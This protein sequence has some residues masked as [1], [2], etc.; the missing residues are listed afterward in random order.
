MLF[1]FV[2]EFIKPTY[3]PYLGLSAIQIACA[4]GAATCVQ[5]LWRGRLAR[6]APQRD[7]TVGPTPTP[8]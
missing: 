3:K 6:A 5:Q 8:Q 4:I 2:V 7:S 1:R